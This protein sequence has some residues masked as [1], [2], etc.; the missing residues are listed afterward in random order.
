M[1]T[2]VGMGFAKIFWHVLIALSLTA[3]YAVAQIVISEIMYDSPGDGKQPEYLEIANIGVEPIDVGGWKIT[4]GSSTDEVIADTQGTV[5]DA[6]Q[7]GL[8][9]DP[10]Y[11]GGDRA[12]DPLPSGAVILTITSKGFGRGTFANSTARIISIIKPD[13]TVVGSVLYPLGNTPGH[14]TERIALDQPFR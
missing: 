12:Y 9:L 6:S 4:D 13:S 7:Y 8:I 14:S 10:D 1:S 2:S 5:I 3:G 11:F